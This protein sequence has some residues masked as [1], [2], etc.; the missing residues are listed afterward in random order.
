MEKKSI[1]KNF[2]IIEAFYDR[3]NIYLKDQRY[4]FQ[5]YKVLVYSLEHLNESKRLI[6][7]IEDKKRFVQVENQ[8][9]DIIKKLRKRKLSKMKKASLLL[10]GINPCFVFNMGIK[11]RGLL[12]KFL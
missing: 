9:K 8:T 10:I 3:I 6:T 5:A 11:F 4:T 12:E 7:N 1:E 2:D